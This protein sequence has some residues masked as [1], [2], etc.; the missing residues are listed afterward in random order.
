MPRYIKLFTTKSSDLE[1][2]LHL[3]AQQGQVEACQ[4]RGDLLTDVSEYG[5]MSQEVNK[6][7]VNSL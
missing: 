3:A 6:W 7:F 1:I 4:K 5:W 2:P